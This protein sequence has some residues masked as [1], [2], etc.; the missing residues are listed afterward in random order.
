MHGWDTDVSEWL[1]SAIRSVLYILNN[2]RPNFGRRVI[3]PNVEFHEPWI[4]YQLIIARRKHPMSY[5]SYHDRYN[6]PWTFQSTCAS[7]RNWLYAV[8]QR[9]RYT[10]EFKT[11]QIMFKD[12]KTCRVTNYVF[13]PVN[14][15]LRHPSMTFYS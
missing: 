9:F 3:L 14:A 11:N 15:T 2:F 7:F 5:D 6:H 8:L 10:V 12:Y 1:I 4:V 13:G